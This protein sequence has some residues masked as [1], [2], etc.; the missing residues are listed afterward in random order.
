MLFDT[1]NVPPIPVV[2]AVS[3]ADKTVCIRWMDNRKRWSNEHWINLGGSGSPS[4]MVRRLF[5]MGQYRTRQYEIVI[6]DE[7][8]LIVVRV[9]EEGETLS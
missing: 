2:P 9:E 7:S 5:R 3:Y 1:P 8:F 6:T 4:P